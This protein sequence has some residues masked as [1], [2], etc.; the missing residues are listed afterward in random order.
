MEKRPVV[1]EEVTVGKRV[2]QDTERV[3]GEVRKE[4][5]RVERE[6]TWTFAGAGPTRSDPGWLGEAPAG[7]LPAGAPRTVRRQPGPGPPSASGAPGPRFRRRDIRPSGITPWPLSEGVYDAPMSIEPGR[8]VTLVSRHGSSGVSRSIGSDNTS[9]SESGTSGR[10]MGNDH[11]AGCPTLPSGPL[12]ELSQGP[13]T[14]RHE[15][16]DGTASLH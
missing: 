13:P 2:V 3:G 14:A 1:K 9:G 10:P 15:G 7:I 6:G 5:V 12:S 4:E 11:G 8:S 16:V